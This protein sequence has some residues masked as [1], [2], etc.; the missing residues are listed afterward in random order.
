ML[1]AIV[2]FWII[3]TFLCWTS[4]CFVCVR[5]FRPHGDSWIVVGSVAVAF[6]LLGI[7]FR[8]AAFSIAWK[9]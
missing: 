8:A 1:N 7:L 2:P 4:I 5:P 3:G 9:I 6:F